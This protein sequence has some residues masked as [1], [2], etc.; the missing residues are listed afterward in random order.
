M[1]TGTVFCSVLSLFISCQHP[2][3][4]SMAMVLSV[5]V[6]PVVSTFTQKLPEEHLNYIFAEKELP[7]KMQEQTL[8][9]K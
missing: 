6:V 9:S 8:T 3:R 2:S 4:G 1:L 7:L 5:V